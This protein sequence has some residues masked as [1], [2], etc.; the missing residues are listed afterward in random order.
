LQALRGNILA[1]QRMQASDCLACLDD[2]A[3]KL[4]GLGHHRSGG[5]T[6]GLL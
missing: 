2:L 5:R 4:L 6:S 1:L 3:K